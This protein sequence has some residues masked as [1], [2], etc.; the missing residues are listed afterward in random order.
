YL[1]LDQ[2]ARYFAVLAWIANSDSILGIGQNYYVYLHPQTRKLLFSAWDQDFSFGRGS[3]GWN[4]YYPW[5]GSNVFLGRVYNVPAFH[6]AY[7]ARMN[8]FSRTIFKPER[9]AAAIKLIAPVIRPAIQEEGT[10]WLAPF[11]R[12]VAGE[13]GIMPYVRA[14][15][16]FVES[17]L[18]QPQ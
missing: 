13:A 17:A 12:I 1:D 10:Q 4:I 18:A 16:V 2:F 8:E 9:F 14:R 5:Q 6:N 7:L 3:P 15:A 11:D